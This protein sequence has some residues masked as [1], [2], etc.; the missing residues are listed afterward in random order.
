MCVTFIIIRYKHGMWLCVL[1][2]YILFIKLN[3]NHFCI[4]IPALHVYALVIT[5][6]QKCR[7]IQHNSSPG[8]WPIWEGICICLH[9]WSRPQQCQFL[10]T[11][12]GLFKYRWFDLEQI[13]DC[14]M[15]QPQPWPLSATYKTVCNCNCKL[16][17]FCTQMIKAGA[18][19]SCSQVVILAAAQETRL[20]W[21]Q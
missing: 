1:L 16:K 7:Q 10:A 11:L 14:G 6:F 17:L 15:F 9:S 21:T 13:I 18:K 20:Y 12:H 19:T 4:A 5:D 8:L 2:E 3:T